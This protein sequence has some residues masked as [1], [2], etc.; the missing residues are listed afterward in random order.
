[1]SV[2]ARRR[3]PRRPVSLSL[4]KLR[5]SARLADPTSPRIALAFSRAAL[6][7]L[8][9]NLARLSSGCRSAVAAI[10]GGGVP[11]GAPGASAAA[12]EA[13]AR[14]RPRAFIPAQAR[15]IVLR[16]CHP[17]VYVLC[18]GTPLGG[19]RII[20][21]LATNAQTLSPDCYAAVA[22]VS[23]QSLETSLSAP[24]KKVRAR[25]RKRRSGPLAA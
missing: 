3:T 16:A 23:Q 1:M 4:L 5:R 8:Q 22:H 2:K 7:C 19:G 17:D 11:A 9:N 25:G 20:D 12:S 21:C 6:A 10:G 13:P 24:T 15:L 14:L 18:G